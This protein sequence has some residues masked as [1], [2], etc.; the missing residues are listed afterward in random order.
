VGKHSLYA[1]KFIRLFYLLIQ[2]TRAADYGRWCVY[3]M[4]EREIH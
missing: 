1:D 4:K 2:L 3:W